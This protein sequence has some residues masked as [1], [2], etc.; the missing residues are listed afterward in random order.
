MA[1]R[2]WYFMLFILSA[3]KEFYILAVV[4]F[5]NHDSEAAKEKENKIKTQNIVCC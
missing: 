1:S 2:E 5:A 3:V 4:I